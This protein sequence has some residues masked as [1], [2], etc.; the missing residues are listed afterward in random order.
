MLSLD[1]WRTWRAEHPLS[2][3]DALAVVIIFATTMALFYAWAG[4]SQA[5]ADGFFAL[6]QSFLHGHLTIDGSRPWI[7]VAAGPG[8]GLWYLPFPPVPSVVLM[9]IVALFGTDWIDTSGTTAFVGGINII[10]IWLLLRRLSLTRGQAAW[11]T[12]AFALGSEFTYVAQV[13]GIHHWV[14]A[15]GLMFALAAL[16]LAVRQQWPLW[17]GFLL[18][19]AA[20][21]R[22]TFLLA[23]P[24]Y[25]WLYMADAPRRE[26]RGHWKIWA[27]RVAQFCIGAIPVGLGL[28]AY[29]LARFGSAFEFGYDRIVSQTNGASVLSEPWYTH[30]IESI[31]YIP[32]G[33]F[34]MLL[35]GPNYSDAFP[36]VQ[37][38]WAGASILL[39]MPVLFFL[40]RATWHDRLI[41]IGWLGLTL[42]LLADLMHGNPGY[43][44]FGYRFFLDGLPFAWL[45]LA[46]V[47][48]RHGLTTGMKGAIIAGIAVYGYAI[49]CISAGFMS[50]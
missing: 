47:V 32:R 38:S 15:L 12:A 35:R 28:L 41:A 26:W 36:Y 37:P 34:T 23:A 6:A 29:N 20:G 5:N 40:G 19:L 2:D 8:P 21:C 13:G 33:L 30:G 10:L 27:D 17:A 1:R 9:P 39:T 44:Q 42:P 18:L 11:L 45:L 22:P 14:Q 48:R 50:S 24:A 49:L 46:L 7:E 25:L 16:T 4:Q 43:A 31:T 3:S